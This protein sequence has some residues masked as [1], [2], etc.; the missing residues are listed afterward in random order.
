MERP[1]RHIDVERVGDICCARLRQPKLDEAALYEM[2]D[3]LNRLAAEDGCRKLVLSLGPKDPE[4]LYSVFLAKLVALQR[5]MQAGGGALKLCDVSPVTRTI[6]DACRLTPLFDF[7][8]D[9]AAAVKAF[10]G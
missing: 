7:A 1:Y 2:T 5:R 9:M 6:F 4:C 3:E 10:S 8:P